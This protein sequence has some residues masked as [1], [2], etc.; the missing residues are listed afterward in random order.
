MDEQPTNGI[1]EDFRIE[2][3]NCWNRLPNKG[4]FLFLFVAWLALFQFLGNSTFGYVPT[5]SLLRWMYEAYHPARESPFSDDAHGLYIPLVVLGIFWWRRKELLALRLE[6]W[7]PGLILVALGL[8]LHVTGYAAQQ[9]RIS[10]IALFVGIYGLM[11]TAWGPAFLK[12]S[13]FPFFLLGF[14]VPLGSL[15]EPVTFPL[16]LMVCRIVEFISH[17]ILAIDVLRQGTRLMDPTGQYSYE[18]AVACSGMRSLI[19]TVALAFIYAFLALRPVWKRGILIAAAVPLAVLSNVVRMLMI[20]IS[21]EVGGK[22][23][24]DYV[25]EGGPLGLISLTPYVIGFGGLF[26][27]GY[28]LN[29]DE[30]ELAL[31]QPA[32]AA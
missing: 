6:N 18:V 16:R 7:W 24:G 12:A 21:A 19:V 20:I 22:A 13:F 28:W 26:L 14:C 25:H 31:P 2:F 4:F 30:P 17:N 15:A 8:A 11:G 9:P 3:L 1:L 29:K 10:I 27:L 32:G 5:P 23:A